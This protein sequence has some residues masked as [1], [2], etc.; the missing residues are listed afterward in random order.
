V[1]E[2]HV[3]EQLALG[4]SLRESKTAGR[5]T[6]DQLKHY[7]TMPFGGPDKSCAEKLLLISYPAI[8]LNLMPVSESVNRLQCLT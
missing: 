5:Q 4:R 2:A 8:Q 6:R 3:C 1:T 7:T